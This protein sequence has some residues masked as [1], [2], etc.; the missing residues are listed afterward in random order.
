MLRLSLLSLAFLLFACGPASEKVDPLSGVKRRL[1]VPDCA[2]G[3]NPIP[4]DRSGKVL[5]GLDAIPMGRYV[6]TSTKIYSFVGDRRQTAV[7]YAEHAA[8]GSAQILCTNLTEN[9]HF[10]YLFPGFSS[11]IKEQKETVYG[12][13]FTFL[14]DDGVGSVTVSDDRL[15][16]DPNM[17]AVLRFFH[18]L[19]IYDLGEGQYDIRGERIEIIG[20]KRLRTVASFEFKKL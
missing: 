20:H 8:G 3:F 16:E 10:G 7:T 17:S 5:P 18:T 2:N 12:R 13:T 6:V 14:W 4:L 19:A 9:D 11:W 15:S 1:S